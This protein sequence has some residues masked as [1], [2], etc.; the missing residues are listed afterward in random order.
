MG[1]NISVYLSDGAL[2][3]L[4]DAV[5]RQ[6]QVDRD[7]G[8]TGRK[9]ASRSSVLQSLIE[10][11]FGE[12]PVLDQQ[13][14]RYHVVSLAEEYGARKVSL[15]GSYARGEAGANSDVDLLLDKGAIR[16]M[17]VLDFQDELSARLGCKV[18]VV[19]TAGASQRFLDKIS[20]D[21]VVLYEAS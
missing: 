3:K 8:L 12:R 10:E 6:A 17:R 11:T 2:R 14:I 16:G 9:V 1:Q 19:T 5:S 18:D 15:F 4:D 13:T 21:E 7:H 20:A